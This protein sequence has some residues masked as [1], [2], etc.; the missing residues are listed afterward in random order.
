MNIVTAIAD[1][2]P[3]KE[4]IARN[5]VAQSASQA[6]D[7]PLDNRFL[8][9]IQQMRNLRL[10]VSFGRISLK[11]GSEAMTDRMAED[12]ASIAHPGLWESLVRLVQ[13]ARQALRERGWSDDQIEAELNKPRRK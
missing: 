10:P 4:L 11:S 12:T 1:P 5:L 13:V 8:H 9:L 3:E 6:A 2:V 7:V